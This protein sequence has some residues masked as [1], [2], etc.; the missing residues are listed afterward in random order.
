MSNEKK[1]LSVKTKMYIFVVVT[2]LSVAV[3]T[4]LIAYSLSVDQIDR[5][6]K[7][8]ASDNALNM[9]DQIDG[10]FI[11]ELRP[12]IESD[13]FQELRERAE[14]E[15]N[16]QLVEDYLK[17]HGLWERY[18]EIRTMLTRYVDNID[19]VKYLYVIAHGDKDAEYDMYLIDDEYSPIYETGYY[20]ER[21]TELR[22]IDLTDLKEPTISNGDWGWLCSDFKPV[23]DSE[24]NCVCIVGCDF[25]MDEV[26]EERTSTLASLIFGSIIFTTIV[27]GIAVW[28]INL[29]LINPIRSM[30]DEMKK[31]RPGEHKDYDTAGVM[32]LNIQSN[33]EIS[34]IYDG[35]RTMQMNIIDY[36][37]DKAKAQSD[38]KH[39]DERIGQLSN[40]TNKDPLTGVGSKYAFIKKTA[41]MNAKIASGESDPFAIVMVDMNNLKNIN[42]DH[43]HKAGDMYIIG[44][45]KMIGEVFGNSPCY[46]IGGDE[47]VVV[48]TGSD[49]EDRKA[50]VEKLKSDYEEAHAA[51]DKEPWERYS[52]A[53]GMAENASDDRTVEFVFKRADKAMYEDK[54]A[55][56][57]NFGGYR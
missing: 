38:I 21:E 34:D 42:D 55:F 35:I 32:E 16:E 41:E 23:Y 31:F 51:S 19:G 18:S 40:E 52:A 7:Q 17:E 46:R 30:T 57:K 10:D 6:Y 14:E 12:Y 47:F 9:A 54:A 39:R 37:K 29:I 22:G 13:E 48:L 26:M 45:C 5:Y 11:A 4:S 2:V 56:K 53:V 33:D 15:D 3:G 8:S 36:L 1:R 25:G 50:L 43:G 20:E 44:C 24:G 27:L 49:Y 28:F